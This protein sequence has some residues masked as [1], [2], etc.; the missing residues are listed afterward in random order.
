MF[1]TANTIGNELATHLVV[2]MTTIPQQKRLRLITSHAVAAQFTGSEFKRASHAVKLQLHK[3]GS[4][5][6]P[7]M[8]VCNSVVSFF[9]IFSAQYKVCISKV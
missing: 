5:N 6:Y 4:L 2:T 8:I 7:K 3:S 1:H 9:L